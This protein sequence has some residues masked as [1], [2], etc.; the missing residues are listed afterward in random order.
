M[1]KF[2]HIGLI[3]VKQNVTKLNILLEG[4][5]DIKYCIAM[6]LNDNVSETNTL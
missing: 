4:V 3:I 2:T 6:L 5:Y 1:H